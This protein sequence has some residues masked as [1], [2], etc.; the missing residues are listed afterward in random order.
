MNN[1][2]QALPVILRQS[3]ADEQVREQLAFAVWRKVAGEAVAQVSAP[4]HL[5]RHTLRVAVLDQ[6]WKTQ[7][8]K[9]AREYLARMNRITGEKIVKA[10]EFQV[11]REAVGQAH[12]AE[13]PSFAF[14][15][16]DEIMDQLHAAAEK[17]KDEQLREAFLHAA[18]RSLERKEEKDSHSR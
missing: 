16:T 4:V 5:D 13:P 11:D 2:F 15:H 14:H 12:P 17:I 10:I 3:G 6:T 9:I 1:L 8:E 7:L 18:A